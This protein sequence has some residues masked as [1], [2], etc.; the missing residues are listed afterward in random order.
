MTEECRIRTKISA[1]DQYSVIEKREITSRKKRRL[2]QKGKNGAETSISSNKNTR[3][4]L[5][6]GN[7]P[8]AS[9]KNDFIVKT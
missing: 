9:N 3:L 5:A 4:L 6:A 2:V 8:S 1:A 7:I